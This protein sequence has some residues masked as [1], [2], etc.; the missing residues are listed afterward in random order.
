MPILCRVVETSLFSVDN[1]YYTISSSYFDLFT[2]F[3]SII[4]LFMF[5]PKIIYFKLF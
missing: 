3:F 1:L 2:S 5:M 4:Y